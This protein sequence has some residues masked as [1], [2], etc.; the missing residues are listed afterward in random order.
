MNAGTQ[1]ISSS[2]SAQHSDPQDA[3][4]TLSVH[5]LISVNLIYKL[6]PRHTYKFVSSV[7]LGL[8]IGLIEDINPL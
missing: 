3:I 6:F 4:L 2:Y 1:L 8:A 5:F 7:I